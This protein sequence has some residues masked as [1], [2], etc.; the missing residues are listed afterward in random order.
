MT[1]FQTQAQHTEKQIK[2]EFEKLH[3]F[4][5]DEEEARIRALKEEHAKL[6]D[7]FAKVDARK[8]DLEEKMV[9]IVQERNDLHLQMSSVSV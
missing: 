7:M 8:K 5:K 4:L 9:S 6:K 2:E 3:Q 1:L